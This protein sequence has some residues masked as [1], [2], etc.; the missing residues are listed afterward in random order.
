M[1]LA[2]ERNPVLS[3]YFKTSKIFPRYKRLTLI[4]LLIELNLFMTSLIF[5]TG[6]SQRRLRANVYMI[7]L[8]LD[9]LLFVLLLVLTKV[10]KEKLKTALG[11][12]EFLQQLEE[13]RKEG[14]IKM[15]I[16]SI[17]AGIFTLVCFSQMM[18]FAAMYPYLYIQ[19]M[20]AGAVMSI[21]HLGIFDIFWCAILALVYVK[22]YDSDHYRALYR[23]LSL[24]AWKI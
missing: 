18:L 9:W 21:V 1:K 8:I 16:L 13:V 15:I 10:S 2:I 5:L 22:G 23:C 6:K 3:V 17:I 11:F 19:L 7:Y 4:F 12:E 24:T 14:L 20:I